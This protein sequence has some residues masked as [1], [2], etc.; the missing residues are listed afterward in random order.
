R[1]RRA[2]ARLTR[3]AR[4]HHWPPLGVERLT[5]QATFRELLAR[6]DREALTERAPIDRS[7]SHATALPPR[8][9]DVGPGSRALPPRALLPD[10]LPFVG[11]RF[12]GGEPTIAIRP[13]ARFHQGPLPGFVDPDRVGPAIARF[14]SRV[15]GPLRTG[16]LPARIAR[17]EEPIRH[18]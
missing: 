16:G 6:S 12:R 8:R 13:A 7:G 2:A 3:R 9:R 15:G 18:G 5:G 17:A 14:L 1:R 11:S 10:D 4:D